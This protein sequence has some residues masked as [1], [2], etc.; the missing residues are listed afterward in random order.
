MEKSYQK[1]INL[2]LKQRCDNLNKNDISPSLEIILI[3]DNPESRKYVELKKKTCL[4]IGVD[5]NLR[6]Y[7]KNVTEKEIIEELVKLNNDK[8]IHGIIIQLPLPKHLDEVNILNKISVDKDVDGFH[9]I[10]AG[11]LFLHL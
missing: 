1:N 8:S 6:E 11:K 3:G 2:R 4:K 10:N 7:D 5:F 9:E